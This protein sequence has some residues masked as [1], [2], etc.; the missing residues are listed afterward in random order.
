LASEGLPT[1]ALVA[2]AVTAEPKKKLETE[3]TR[4]ESAVKKLFAKSVAAPDGD[5]TYVMA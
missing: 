1:A 2:A 3:A 4:V 5:A